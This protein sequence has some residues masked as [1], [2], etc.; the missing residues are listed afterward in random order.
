MVIS[1][2]DKKTWE[3]F[4]ETGLLWWINSILHTFGWSIVID[5]DGDKIVG[6]YPSRVKFRGFS[7]QMNT[8]GYQKVS[9]YLVENAPE[10]KKE[11]FE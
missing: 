4:R 3:E 7:E 2:V 1:L 6:V 10:L 11:A 9:N 5:V 8:Q